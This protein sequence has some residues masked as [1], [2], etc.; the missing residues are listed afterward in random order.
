MR[1]NLRKTRI[2][3]DKLSDE[4]NILS[5]RQIEN[6]NFFPLFYFIPKRIFVNIFWIE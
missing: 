5:G 6:I 3:R 2:K 4:V 1:E